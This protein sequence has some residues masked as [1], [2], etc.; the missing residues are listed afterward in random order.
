MKPTSAARA[1]YWT[2]Q[3]GKYVAKGKPLSKRFCEALASQTFIN[4]TVS[5]EGIPQYMPDR[6]PMAVAALNELYSPYPEALAAM[7][8]IKEPIVISAP[9]ATRGRTKPV[10]SPAGKTISVKFREP[11][12]SKAVLKLIEHGRPVLLVGLAGSGKTRLFHNLA[13]KAGKQIYRVNFDGGMTPDAFLGGVRLRPV[14]NPDG[15]VSQETY[16]QEGPVLKAA[17]EGAWLLLDEIDKIQP[18]YVAALHAMLEDVHNPITVNDDG[19]HAIIPHP[20]F[21]VMG[22]ANTLGEM[23]DNALGYYGSSPMNAAFKDRWSILQV[24]YPPDETSIVNDVLKNRDLSEGLVKVAKL[25]RQAIAESKLNG[26]PFSTRRLIAWA[27]AFKYLG[28]FDYATELE[29]LGRYTEAS[30][31]LV[32]SF[33]SNVF[34]NTWRSLSDKPDK[35]AAS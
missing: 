23:E 18:E 5:V 16:F 11:K 33:I 14:K 20:D 27:T 30:R 28:D 6:S 2:K 29:I 17:L 13:R 15:S 8:A 19:G 35:Q 25:A 21:R 12:Y 7:L 3:V 1:A 4:Q 34:G 32:E 24:G 31:S 26:M 10:V 9:G 22:A